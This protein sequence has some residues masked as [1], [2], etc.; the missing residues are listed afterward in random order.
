LLRQARKGANDELCLIE[1]VL[2]IVYGL[3]IL[4]STILSKSGSNGLERGD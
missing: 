2:V 1:S 4:R 3:R